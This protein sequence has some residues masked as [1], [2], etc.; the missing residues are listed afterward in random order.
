MDERTKI[1]TRLDQRKQV[2]LNHFASLYRLLD[3]GSLD[4]TEPAREWLE[5]FCI[6]T[7]VQLCPGDFSIGKS[8]GV[9]QDN[10]KLGTDIWGHVDQFRGG[11]SPLDYIVTNYL[12]YMP[13][14]NRV[15]NEWADK[16]A[17]GGLL[18]IAALNTDA[19][20]DPIGPLRND[21]RYHCFTLRTLTAYLARAG[22]RVF[23]W[24]VPGTALY[25]A[26]K[27]RQK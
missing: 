17:P 27:K 11:L 7:G 22:L 8:L 6:G 3:A 26:A 5:Q 20:I 19:Y 13:D 4:N 21:R 15:L 16:L 18:A 2:M 9:D 1:R 12:E 10:A 14:T 24:E 25:V 23:Q